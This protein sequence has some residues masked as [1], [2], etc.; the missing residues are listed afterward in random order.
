MFAVEGLDSARH[1]NNYGFF[2]VTVLSKDIVS[3]FSVFLEISLFRKV[4]ENLMCLHNE[5]KFMFDLVFFSTF[6]LGL[7]RL[8][9]YLRLTLVSVW[10][11]TRR[12]G[13]NFC[14]SRVLCYCWRGNYHSMG[15]GHF[16]P[17]VS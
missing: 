2:F 1:L 6:L 5:L 10:G 11:S 15:L 14:F 17:G 7:Q 16:L 4:S 9:E 13:F 8:A 3:L 12:E